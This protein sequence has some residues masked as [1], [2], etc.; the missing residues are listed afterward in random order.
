VPPKVGSPFLSCKRD[1]RNP[2]TSPGPVA[3]RRD[4]KR[5][6][7]RDRSSRMV[8]HRVAPISQPALFAKSTF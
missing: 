2:A 4:A 6:G 3:R 5:R 8:H 7:A 1:P